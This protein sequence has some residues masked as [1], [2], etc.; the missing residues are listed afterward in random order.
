MKITFL[1]TQSLESP[2]GNG[3]FFPLAKALVQAGH[4]VTIIALHH[5]FANAPKYSFTQD[6]VKVLYVAQMH[7]H[8]QGNHKSYF[9][10]TQLLWVAAVATWRLAW[11]AWRTPSDL[12]HVCKTQPM[13]GIAAWV[14]HLLRGTPVFLDSDDYEASNNRFSSPLQQRI[15]A[16]FE[17][18]LPSFASGI[19]AGN[20]FIAHHFASIG[21]PTNRIVIVYNGVERE[22]FAVLN[23]PAVAAKRLQT[24]REEL[25]LVPTQPV[26]GY[27]GSM[28]L[29]SHAVD[30]LLVAFAE[31]VAALP[32]AVLL[33]VGSGEDFARLQTQAA[34]LGLSQSVRFV[35]RVP[36]AEIPFYYALANITVDPLQRTIP[37]ESSLSLKLME[38]LAAGVPCVTTDIGDRAQ[39]VGEAGTAVSPGNPQAMATA[40]I[41][42]LPDQTR[43]AQMRAAAQQQQ[44]NLWWESRLPQFT[45]LYQLYPTKPIA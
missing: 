34:T 17:D 4:Q 41:Q 29:V 8:K 5:D 37:A 7:V 16:W 19:T 1:L 18:W 36:S 30:L 13:N 10:P 40:I 11:A 14:V 21:Y 33:L 32:T 28:S 35:G 43:L 42:L 6:G 22:R 45:Q 3:R 26:V 12:L 15:V 25:D 2:G 39:M 24:L 9:S 31:V 44:A 20:R 27:I 23:D 38:S